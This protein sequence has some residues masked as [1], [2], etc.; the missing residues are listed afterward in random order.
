MREGAARAGSEVRISLNGGLTVAEREAI[1]AKL[2]PGTYVGGVGD[3]GTYFRTAGANLGADYWDAGLARRRPQ[4]YDRVRRG[5]AVDLRPGARPETLRAEV[6]MDAY[7]LP[8]ARVLLDSARDHP[9]AGLLQRDRVLLHAG[10]KLVGEAQAEALVR[11]WESV[12]TA[13]HAVAQVRQ[14]GCSDILFGE[15]ASRW[16]LRPLVPRPLALT[17]EEKAHYEPFLFSVGSDEQNANLGYLFGKPVLLGDGVVWMARWACQEAIGT[18][19]GAAHRLAEILK[20]AGDAATGEAQLYRARVQ[21]LA[22]VI[23]NVKL[24]LMYQ[25]ALNLADIPRFGANAMDY[26]D[27]MQYDQRCLELRKIARADLDNTAALIK[28]LGEH[29]EPLL[30]LAETPEGETVFKFGPH[31]VAALQRKLEIMLDH[32]HEYELLYPTSKEWEFEPTALRERRD[33]PA[34]TGQ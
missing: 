16:L 26:D 8:L 32:W 14:R 13:L 28:L 15:T 34:A 5:S 33:G 21:A 11:V 9:G 18:L 23:E 22:C 12:N 25:H 24:T 19:Q 6:S 3:D 10:A 31:L 20:E 17:E 1:R 7:C 2:T 27:N 29:P 30:A 4:Q